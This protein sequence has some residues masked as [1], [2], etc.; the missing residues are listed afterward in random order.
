MTEEQL[1]LAQWLPYRAD[2]NAD[3]GG[4]SFYFFDLDNNIL[5]LPTEII[6]FH[7][8][9]RQELPILPDELAGRKTDRKGGQVP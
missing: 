4:R 7:R 6:L 8:E 3:Y 9:T 1:E 2:R 5:H